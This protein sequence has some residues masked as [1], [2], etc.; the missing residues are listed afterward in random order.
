MLAIAL[1]AHKNAPKYG[2]GFP[3]AVAL[4]T[5]VLL[6][7]G[8]T[9]F[10]AYCANGHLCQKPKFWP[11]L[12]WMCWVAERGNCNCQMVEG[13]CQCWGNEFCDSVMVQG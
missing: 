4:S 6:A 3:L 5:A 10:G 2:H 1:T 13:V 12:G 11:T 8:S 7:V 9:A